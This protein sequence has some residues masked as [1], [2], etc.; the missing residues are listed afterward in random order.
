M[1]PLGRDL[2]DLQ[3]NERPWFEHHW[4]GKGPRRA[5][6]ISN[7]QSGNVVNLFVLIL[8]SRVAHIEAVELTC[9]HKAGP[10]LKDALRP[11]EDLIESER[12]ASSRFA[13]LGLS[14]KPQ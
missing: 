10:D 8:A 12:S 13:A 11:V 3:P 5:V 6:A 7:T 2:F 9:R 1:C 14:L 4:L